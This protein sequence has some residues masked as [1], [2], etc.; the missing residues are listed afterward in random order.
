MSSYKSG[1]EGHDAMRSKAEKEFGA[2]FHQNMKVPESMSS[3]DNARMRPYADGGRVH[4][5]SEGQKNLRLPRA[6][7]GKH[8]GQPKMQRVEHKALGGMLGGMAK[9]AFNTGRSLTGFSKGGNCKAEGGAMKKAGGGMARFEK[10]GKAKANG[11]EMKRFDGGGMARFAEGGTVKKSLGGAMQKFGSGVASVGSKVQSIGNSIGSRVQSVGNS[12]RNAATPTA[13]S[14]GGEMKRYN[15]GSAVKKA[16]GGPLG[17]F[18][19][20]GINA[21]RNFGQNAMGSAQ[22]MGQNAMGAVQNTAQNVGQGVQ[23]AANNVANGFRKTFGFKKGG[24]VQPD[25]MLRASHTRMDG[26]HRVRKAVGGNVNAQVMGG[27]R[28]G[29]TD[30]AMRGERPVA[31]SFGGILGNIGRGVANVAGG[32]MGGVPK[33]AFNAARSVTG[34][35][36]GGQ[37]KANGGPMKKMSGGFCGVDRMPRM[38]PRAMPLAAGGVG[39]IRHNQA[40]KDGSPKGR[41]R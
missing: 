7:Q 31:K 23:G 36:N 25:G 34:L 3:R 16:W 28:G 11:G 5:L 24:K 18:M 30:V 20:N 13:K 14:Q 17:N 15:A 8:I 12:I 9:Q 39:K 4:G 38:A 27:R 37:A 26:E 2:E 21:T 22:N 33:Q 1:Y 19:N 35:K 40:T 41:K 29:A 6:Q 32:M 10:G